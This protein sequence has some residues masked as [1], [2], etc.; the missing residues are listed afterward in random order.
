LLEPLAQGSSFGTRL[1][2]KTLCP[3]AYMSSITISP[4]KAAAPTRRSRYQPN[5]STE[6][7][8]A[9]H[10]IGLFEITRAVRVSPE[11]AVATTVFVICWL[12]RLLRGMVLAEVV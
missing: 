8:C 11:S 7:S 1:W 2:K 10:V 6:P 12:T 9:Y 3:S 5:L 4:S